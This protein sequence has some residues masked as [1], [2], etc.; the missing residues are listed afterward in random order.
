M[1]PANSESFISSSPVFLERDKGHGQMQIA[2]VEKE[3]FF[4]V[5]MEGVKTMSHKVLLK[6][7]FE[8]GGMYPKVSFFLILFL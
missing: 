5:A 2:F 3:C 8:R 1:S 4:K 6:L 7:Q